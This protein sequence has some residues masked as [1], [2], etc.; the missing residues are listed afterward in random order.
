LPGKRA[1]QAVRLEL[2]LGFAPVNV[3]D[4]IRHRGV[5]VARHE[6]GAE[7]GDGFYLW[8]GGHALITVNSSE[9]ASRQRFTAAHELGHHE[10]HRFEA[11]ELA[12]ADK[13]VFDTRGNPLEI[14]ANAFAGY[15]LAPDEALQQNLAGRSGKDVAPR[16]VVDLMRKYG[17]S[18]EATANRLNLAGI[19]NQSNRKRLLEEGEGQVERLVREAGFDE[20]TVFPFGPD[21]PAELV[22]GALA[23]YRDAVISA[24]RL[25]DILGLAPEHA[26]VIAAERGYARPEDPLYD[27][28][29]AQLVT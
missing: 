5:D 29:V 28:S 19:V 27:E 21:L 10:L 23:L 7:S 6:F 17:L 15:L 11:S 16:D 25:G 9:R 24:D 20:E 18:Y 22:D 2:N 12:I 4:V 26:V 3:W 13:D 14:A 8:R 1:A